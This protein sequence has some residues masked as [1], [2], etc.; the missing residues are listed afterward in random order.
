MDIEEYVRENP[1]VYAAFKKF[2]IQAAATGRRRLSARLVIERLRWET[3]VTEGGSD[4]KINNDI[5]PGL[6]RKLM[7]DHPLFAGFFETR[8]KK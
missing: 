7:T 8:T 6:A 5:A 1:E 3:M 2:T 4:F